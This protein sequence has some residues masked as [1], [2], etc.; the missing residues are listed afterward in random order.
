MEDPATLHLS[1]A[2]QTNLAVRDPGDAIYVQWQIEHCSVH[3][4]LRKQIRVDLKNCL[5]LRAIQ[6][7]ASTPA[8]YQNLTKSPLIKGS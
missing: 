5:T 8:F 3:A 4:N 6:K 2:Q 1:I 7:Q